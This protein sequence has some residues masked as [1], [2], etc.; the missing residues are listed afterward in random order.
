MAMK[1]WRCLFC[2]HQHRAEI[3]LTRATHLSHPPCRFS[4]RGFGRLCGSSNHSDACAAKL[5]RE[6]THRLGIQMQIMYG[7]VRTVFCS[8][9]EALTVH[10]FIRRGVHRMLVM[11]RGWWRKHDQ[12][13]MRAWITTERRFGMLFSQR[14]RLKANV[15][16]VTRRDKWKNIELNV[17]K[18][19]LESILRVDACCRG[20]LGNPV[21]SYLMDGK[22]IWCAS[23]PADE[24]FALQINQNLSQVYTTDGCV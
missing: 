15:S 4:K 3:K 11:Q 21:G 13:E 10:V 7:H 16:V 19:Q 12:C 17:T 14:D 9:S 6:T 22:N 20:R 23:A 18:L 24:R 8:T 1:A 2:S 5:L